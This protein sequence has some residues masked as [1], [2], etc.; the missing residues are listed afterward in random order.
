KGFEARFECARVNPQAGCSPVEPATVRFTAPIPLEQARAI[1]LEV[2]GRS[3]APAL[4]KERAATVREVRFA[5][6]LPADV[7]GQ[8]VLP[9]GVADESGR[10]LANARRFPLAVRIDAAPPLVKFAADFGILEAGEGGVLPVTVR[11]VEPTLR[12]STLAVGGKVARIAGDDGTIAQ[13]LRRITKAAA[14]DFREEA[15]GGK[16]VTVNHTGD[17]SILKGVGGANPLSLALPGKGKAFEV[18]GVP[19]KASGFYVVELASPVLGRALLGRDAPR[20]VAAGALVTNMAVH[21]KW[22][23]GT[24][25]AWVTALDSGRPVAGAAVSVTD[26]CSGRSLGDGTSDAQGRLVVRG[27]PEPRSYADCDD[28]DGH[29]LMVSARRGGDFSFTM[30]QWGEGIRPYDFDLPFGWSAPEDIFH[31]ILDRT[32]MRGGETVHMKHV[33]RRPA[34]RG[35][36]LAGAMRGTLRLAHRGSDTVFDLPLTIGA[37]GIGESEWTAP[38]G[39]AQGDYDIRFLIGDRTIFTDQSI[40]VDEYRLPTMRATIA[41]PKTVAIRPASLPVDLYVGYLS[42]GGAAAMPVTVRT[43]FAG[44]EGAPRGWDGWTFGGRAIREG[45][46]P[47]DGDGN[48]IAPPLPSAQT[49]PVTL[50]A[51]G[52]ARIGLD[53]P[54][55]LDGATMVSVEMDYQDA[56]GET[57]TAAT[58]IPVLPAAVRVGVKTDGWLMKDDDLRLKLVVLDPAGRPVKGRKVSVALYSREVLSARRRLI[59]GFYAFDNNARVTKLS[60]SCSTRSDA[61]GLAQCALDPGVSGEVYAVATAEDDAGNVSRAVTSVWLAGDDD[62]WFGGDNG[63]RMDLVPEQR[64]YKA[65]DTARF[66]VRMPFRAATALVTVEREGVLSSFVTDLSGKDPVVSVK[67]GAGYA[68]DVYVSVLAVRGRVAGW[69]LWLAD[70]GRRWNL[71]FFSR[72]GARPTALVDLAK[73]SFRL[74]IAKISVGWEAN[75]LDV[76]VRPDRATYHVRDVAQVAVQVKDAAGRAPP[77]AEIAFVAVDEALLQLSPNPSWKLIEA[78][79]GER[80]LSVLTATAQTQVVGKRHYGRKAVAV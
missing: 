12:G 62:W 7:A 58:R 65:G 36:A 50:S 74:G 53:M 41:G 23:H 49:L 20:Y 38:A 2:A 34:A 44:D 57:L 73:P 32:L 37:N 28:G 8:V 29:P 35:F 54:G 52:T 40:R 18:V 5:A 48:A 21:F 60:A 63:D 16:Q 45:V 43:A 75:R 55:T 1:R 72:E 30:T 71:P 51:Q 80:P 26:A 69:R 27:L 14:N 59:G 68:P 3:I 15:R 79:M 33:V 70:F 47:L 64:E 61:Q 4:E 67:L 39:A 31:T 10:P 42:G 76:A 9:A 17:R 13:W 6:P 66:Q 77:A 11:N 46:S 78:M 24:S 19:L 22:G 25:L 56:N